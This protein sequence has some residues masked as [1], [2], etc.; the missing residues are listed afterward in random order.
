MADHSSP[1]DG[2][3]PAAIFVLVIIAGLVVKYIWWVVG[4]AALAGVV[5]L[6]VVL[7][8]KAEERRLCDEKLAA[9]REFERAR[10]AER[11][12]RWTMIGDSR[13]VYGEKGSAPTADI[14][15]TDSAPD[16]DEPIATLAATKAELDALIRDRPQGWEQ[17]LFASIL[18][19]R[20]A[21]LASRL[22]DSELG[23]TEAGASGLMS[24]GELASTVVHMLDE[25]MRTIQQLDRFMMAPA[26]MAAFSGVDD[27]DE[28]GADP[29]AI[30]HIAHRVMDYHE[31]LLELS[32]RC[33]GISAPAYYDD[34]LADCARMLDAPLRSYR[35]FIDEFAAVIRA[36]PRVLPHAS[37][38][39]D[40]GSLG[41]YISIDNTLH[42]RILRRLD[43]ITAPR[44]A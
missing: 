36:L 18:M 32:E 35:E 9:E 41:L 30:A 31:R 3:V 8:R 33:R 2:S 26:F 5:Y 6:C 21:P 37:G 4:A 28:D 13:A 44:R 19:Q 20:A 1:G 24:A 10:L 22:R 29:E 27:V 42:S 25:M 17:A 43:E 23:Y 7:T 34:I 15:G 14:T 11:Q 16:T 40:L 12:H 38:P 39:V